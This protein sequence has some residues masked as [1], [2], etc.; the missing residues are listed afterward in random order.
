MLKALLIRSK[1]D[2]ARHNLDEH[3]KGNDFESRQ[4][5]LE[6]AVAELTVESTDEERSVLAEAVEKL[7]SERTAWNEKREEL[8]KIVSDTEAELREAEEE[9]P[10]EEEKEPEEVEER[11]SKMTIEEIRS[12]KEYVD[13]YARYIKTEKDDEVR[14]LLTELATGGSIPVPTIVEDRIRT[15][16]S[17]LGVMDLVRKS[18]VKGIL[19]VGFELSA[20]DAAIHEEGDEEPSEEEIVIGVVQL[21]PASIKKWITISDE[22][23]DLTGEA[24]L[25]YIFDEL[26]YRIAKFAQASLIG[27][28]TAASTTASSTAVSVAEI[29]GAPSL[30][31]VAEAVAQL[32]DEAVD[33]VVVINK[34]T[35]AQ[36]EAARVAGGFAVDPYFGLRVFY[37]NTLDEYEEG[38]TGCWMI[39]GDFGRGALANFPAGADIGIKYDDISLA[40]KD[41]VKLVGRQY[42]GMG[43]V[44]DGCFCRVMIPEE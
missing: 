17:K 5:E 39:V 3:L 42:V 10:A 9:A 38:E 35:M 36:F 32:S 13:A 1:L 33:P 22:A 20:T 18:Y 2:A 34:A 12:S 23:M 41:L 6:A 37:D 26:A 24:F 25:D 40:E 16:W 11:E 27:L 43:L 7:E 4:A 31:V 30:S 29:E 15:A 44:Q 8:E 21:V 14:A 19:R 28:V